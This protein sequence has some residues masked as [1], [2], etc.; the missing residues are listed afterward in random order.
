MSDSCGIEIGIGRDA[1]CEDISIEITSTQPA[2]E[3]AVEVDP[4]PEIGVEVR[5]MG[6]NGLTPF[7]GANGNWWIGETDT[8]VQAEG[9]EGPA[10]PQGEP[11]RDGAT[12]SQ[13]PQGERGPAGETGA[14]GPMGPQGIQG[15]KGDKGDPGADGQTGPKGDTGDTGPQGPAGQDGAPGKD[16][17]PGYTPQRGTDYWTDADK[18]EIVQD[19]LGEVEQN[20]SGKVAD[21]QANGASIVNEDGVAVIPNTA[22]GVYG[23][24]RVGNSANGEMHVGN[25]NGR[26]ILRYPVATNAGITARKSQGSQYGGV[27]ASSNIDFAVK[28]AMTDGKGA[29]W[30]EDEQAAARTRMGAVSLEEVL[31]ALPVYNGEVADA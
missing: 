2:F 17:S 10:G 5:V 4:P 30:T 31:A 8:G 1:L 28:A 21:V 15:Q 27:I 22:N 16:G 14:Q 19:V 26:S 24:V 6:D 20:P 9:R 18:A 13:G 12:G 3:A 11:G 23:L 29:D 7:I 25:T